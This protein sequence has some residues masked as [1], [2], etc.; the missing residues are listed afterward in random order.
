MPSG[1]IPEE[2]IQEIRQQ[3]DIVAVISEYVALEQA[4]KNFK[5]CCP[6]HQEK[7]PSFIVS[8]ERQTYHCFG[9][10]AGGN[11]FSFLMQYEKYSFPEAV[12][13]LA[14]RLGI[15]IPEPAGQKDTQQLQRTDLLHQLHREVAN[16][17]AYQLKQSQHAQHARDYLE[18]REIS[19][20][21]IEAFGIGYAPPGWDDIQKHFA[22]KYPMEL[23]LE[24][25]LMIKRKEG[26]GQYDRFRDRLMVPIHDERGRVVAFGGRILGDGEPK[27]LNSPKYL[28]SPESPIFHKGKVLFGL[29]QAKR[30]I[31]Q[32][33]EVILV[34]GY[35]D[36]IVPYSLGVANLAATMGTALTNDH[37]RLLQRY[38]KNVVLMFDADPA[39]IKA[40]QRTLDLF[41]ESG[42]AVRAV[43]LPQKDDPDTAIRRMGA[44]AFRE[45]ITTAP[46]LLDFIRE[47]IMEQFDLSRDDQRVAC[48]NQILAS[49]VKI[50]NITERNEQIRKTAGLLN[51]TEAGERA[52]FEQFKKVARTGKARITTQVDAKPSKLPALE[53]YLLK[54]LLKDKRLIGLLQETGFD[55]A[56]LTHPVSR[57]VVNELFRFGDKTDFEARILDQFR[58]SPHQKILTGLFLQLDEV[59]NPEE[60]LQDCLIRLQQKG[61]ELVTLPR[62]RRLH[63]LQQ[64]K[65]EKAQLDALLE[66]KNRELLE[67]QNF[68]K[69]RE[70]ALEK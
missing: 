23:L 46:T 51:V 24:S 33:D 14:R 11:V 70:L 21:T 61:F 49:I 55:A 50:Q 58:D 69:K 34:E 19:K 47:R 20:A 44:D 32:Q 1:R 41:L 28:N 65:D 53:R 42:F 37:L 16:F 9:C 8:P 54:A 12:H 15:R 60:T 3:A 7:T 40:V 35:F 67:K 13:V 2:S 59:V 25:G 5:G 36:M 64:R 43:I 48:A 38:T 29:H 45:Y 56:V 26:G 39:G 68:I 30:A 52:L 57:A 10:G 6:F 62:T 27:D 31:R 18:Q 63:E 17:F 66:Q 4:G 22:R